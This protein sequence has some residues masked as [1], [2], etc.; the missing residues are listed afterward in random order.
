MKRTS[1]KNY[2]TIETFIQAF[3]NDISLGEQKQKKTP[4]SY[5]ST[6]EKET[7]KSLTNREDVTCNTDNKTQSLKSLNSA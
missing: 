6:N 2:H 7:L 4:S 5:L 3:Q 1:K